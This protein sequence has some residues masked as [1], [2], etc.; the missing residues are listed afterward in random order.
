VKYNPTLDGVRALAVILVIAHHAERLWFPSGWLG[1][2]VFFVLSGYLITCILLVE[3]RQSGRIDLGNFYIRRFLRLTPA[4]A[5]LVAFQLIRSAFSPDGHEIRMATLVGAAYLQ[6][7]NAVFDFVPADVMGHTWS[8]AV[9]EQFYW[10]WP[11]VLPLIFMK[12]PLLWL[13]GAITAMTIIR[14]A[15]WEYGLAIDG[16]VRFFMGERPIGLLIGCALA[17]L[18]IGRCPLSPI[19]G[20][21]SIVFLAALSAFAERSAYADLATPLAASLATAIMIV[22][23]QR[24][25]WLTKCM[26]VDPLAYIGRI[27]YGLYLYHYPLLYL[28]EKLKFHTPFHLYAVGLMALIVLVAALSYEFIEKPCLRLKDRFNDGAKPGTTPP[29]EIVVSPS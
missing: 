13:G 21:A 5:V 27:S 18:P 19:T 29:P 9:E 22:C 6:N 23:S 12:R 11:L 28:G 20:V 2:D 10:L 7:W 4:L 3:L 8:L 17:F 16:P 1:V 15:M 24:Q 26:S 14:L 25:S